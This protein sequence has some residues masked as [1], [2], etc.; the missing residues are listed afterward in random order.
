MAVSDILNWRVL[1]DT[2]TLSGQPTEDELRMLADAGVKHIVNLGPHDNKGALD[3]EPASVAALGM[4]YHY[5]PVDFGAPTEKDYRQFLQVLG[6]C[7]TERTHV[8][9][10]YNARVSAFC[11]RRAVETGEDVDRLAILMDDIWRPGGVWAR[12]IG[13]EKDASLPNRYL[14]YDY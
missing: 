10:I 14:G 7:D 6:G 1:N 9:C 5:I 12:F 13:R 4:V 8:H 2:V 3:D 11:Y